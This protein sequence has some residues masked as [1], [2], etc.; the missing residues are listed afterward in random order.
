VWMRNHVVNPVVRAAART[1]ARRLLGSRLVLLGYTGRRSG[2]RFDVPVMAAPGAEGLVVMVG[3][4]E[5]KTWWRNFAD[6]PRSVTVRTGG[7]VERRSARLLGPDDAGYGEAMAAYRQAFPTVR[8]DAGT[9]LLL[10]RASDYA[11][12]SS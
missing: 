6:G 7:S 1:P 8:P 4:H 12:P 2:R 9:P 5:A 11:S 3:R 10:V